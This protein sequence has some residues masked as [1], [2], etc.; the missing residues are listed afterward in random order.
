MRLYVDLILA[1][2]TYE[3]ININSMMIDILSCQNDLKEQ[4]SP[5]KMGLE[6]KKKWKS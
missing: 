2:N 4:Y 5:T 6:Q 1:L 3:I